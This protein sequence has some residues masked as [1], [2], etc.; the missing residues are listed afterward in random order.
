M[1]DLRIAICGSGM[2]SR[3]VW[4]PLV[5]RTAGMELVGVQD[6]AEESRAR[7]I[8]TGAVAADAAFASLDEMLA[9]TEPDAVIV[10]SVNAAHAESTE[11]ALDAGCHVLVEKP[12]A[13]SLAAAARLAARAEAEGRV[14]GVVQNWRTKT[15]GRAL[16]AALADRV[17]GEP[18]HVFF[19]YLRDREAPHLPDYL[20]GED[21]PILH[22][23]AI[24]HF[25]LF[26]YALRDEV[27]L[28]DA[29]AAHP[30]WSRYEHPSV[31]HAW[32][33]MERGVVVSYTATFSSRNSYLPLESL[34][35]ECELGTL[36]NE[37]AY[38]EPPLLLL[39][40][41]ADTPEDLTADEPV[42]DQAGQYALADAAVL[43]NFRDAVVS[44]AEVV[45]PASDNLN[46]LAVVAAVA[47]S[48]RERRPVDPRGLLAAASEPVMEP[49]A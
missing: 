21:D 49:H 11:A 24:H 30:A 33:E 17:A 38:A 10:A 43:E 28:V 7:A 19:R 8:E 12:F 36:H 3:S 34:Q 48:C 15:V 46:T 6:P 23:M 44:G 20:F 4:Q 9:R 5:A 31:L 29:H 27:A 41:G 18:S 42:R 39:R 1:A 16:R 47:Q 35:V 26:R 37:S 32:L 25:D 2:R 40:R 45:A 14:L 13:T 22:A